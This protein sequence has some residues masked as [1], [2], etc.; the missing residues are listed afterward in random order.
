M[1]KLLHITNGDAAVNVMHKANIS[2][3]ILPWSDVLHEGPVPDNL[4]LQQLS[5]L[6][7]NFIAKQ[8]WGTATE[9]QNKFNNRDQLLLQASQFD[10]VVLWFE[11]D[12]Y[13]QLQLLQI[14][15]FFAAQQ[16]SPIITLINT[17]DYLGPMSA[18]QIAAL[19]PQ[20]RL[21]SSQQFTLARAAWK[22]F[23]ADTPLPWQQLLYSENSSL[24]HLKP[25]ILRMLQEFPDSNNGLSRTMQQSLTLLTQGA[26]PAIQLFELY[27]QTEARR[28]L[29]DTIFWSIINELTLS[30]PALI[31]PRYDDTFDPSATQQELVLTQEGYAV[32]NG[33]INWLDI[34]ILDRWIGG[35]HINK[36]NI[37]CWNHSEQQ[38]DKKA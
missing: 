9:V 35:V 22:A 32:L 21:V 4:T 16:Q 24:Q 27:Q 20:R 36:N 1:H 23:R 17:D 10:E 6:R 30:T 12:L 3:T 14:L 5:E 25:A 38:I 34:T 26:I 18:R 33:E 2:G 7:S 13:D 37:W 31:S 28:F 29:G 11:H 15:D 8:G 19:W